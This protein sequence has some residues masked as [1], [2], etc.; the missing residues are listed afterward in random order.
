[1]IERAEAN[2]SHGRDPADP[3]QSFLV[4][5]AASLPLPDRSFDL[6]ISTLSMHHWADVPAGLAE[7]ARVLRPGGRALIWDFRAGT[8]P[9]PF[10]PR[11]DHM[12][13]PL[14]QVESAA[15]RVVNVTPWGWPS[16]LRLTQRSELVPEVGSGP[17]K[18]SARMMAKD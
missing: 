2:A 13:D 14:S 9:H 10:A 18:A 8:R 1:M 5:D 4:G 3:T 15:L 7:I 16:G 6:V 11:H 17:G 12:A